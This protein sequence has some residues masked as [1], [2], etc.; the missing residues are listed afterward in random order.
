MVLFPLVPLKLL[1]EVGEKWASSRADAW[2][3]RGHWA[4]LP[5]ISHC[6]K[7]GP[8]GERAWSVWPRTPGDSIRELIW[9]RGCLAL[10]STPICQWFLA[11]KEKAKT[12][13]CLQQAILEE[14]RLKKWPY[15]L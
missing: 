4:A 8:P 12:K 10:G 2:P 6:H 13:H 11:I 1:S 15:L 7:P 9:G 5:Y 14:H 3:P